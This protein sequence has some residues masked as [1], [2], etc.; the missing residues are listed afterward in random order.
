MLL[1][2]T[3]FPLESKRVLVNIFKFVKENWE[4][5]NGGG[6]YFRYGSALVIPSLWKQK[7]RR[8]SSLK[9]SLGYMVAPYLNKAKK[10]KKKRQ[11]TVVM[12]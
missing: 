12:I 10:K 9:L 11:K 3:T 8:V 1:I 6:H 2:Y 7:E 4:N 5:L